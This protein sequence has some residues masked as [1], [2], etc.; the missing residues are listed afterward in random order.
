MKL[1]LPGLHSCTTTSSQNPDE[2][3]VESPKLKSNPDDSGLGS[4]VNNKLDEK[5]RDVPRPRRMKKRT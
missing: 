3:D 5:H 4:S 1:S 2:D